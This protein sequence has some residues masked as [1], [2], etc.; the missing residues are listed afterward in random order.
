MKRLFRTKQY[1]TSALALFRSNE[2]AVL[3]LVGFAVMAL[4]GATGLAID[5]SRAQ[6]VQTRLSNSLDAAGLA[7]GS[8][9][10]SGDISATANKYFAANF[11]TGYMGSTIGDISITPN[12]DNTM[13][14]LDVSGTVDTTIMQ[15][16]GVETVAV[17]AHTEITRASRG[18]ELVM[19]LDNTGSM[20]GSRLVNL[21]DAATTL[22]NILYGEDESIDNLWIGLV[23]FSQAVNIGTSRASWTSNPSMPSPGWGPTSWGGCVDARQ[24]SNRDVTD[25]PPSVALFPKYYW[26]CHSSNNNWYGNNSGKNDCDTTGGGFGYNT[27]LSVTRGPNKS[28][29]Q[30]LTAM[31]KY[32]T[33][34]LNGINSMQARGNTHIVLGASWGWRMLSPRWRGLWG[35]EMNDDEL[36]LE[37]DTP[38]MDKVLLI[39]TDG[40]NTIDTSN[41]GAYGYLS[42]GYL[43]TTTQ[44]TAV[45]QLNSRLTTVCNSAKANDILV[46]TIAFGNPGSTIENLLEGCASK[47]EYY[48]NSSNGDELQSAFQQIGDSLANLRISK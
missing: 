29:P 22:V 12:E 38:L 45:N 3:P 35:G 30:E 7:A 40:A 5:M 43:G 34:I 21:K 20:A 8:V 46:Y 2:G 27:P 18:L 44:S 26:A 6:I 23:P 25:D 32:K 1:R 24:A 42:N 9:A 28:C 47:P 4:F 48:F 16:F 14:V 33:T 15:L 17:A 31:T 10:N 39:M 41:R 19:V 11:P 37:Y 36:P 13:L